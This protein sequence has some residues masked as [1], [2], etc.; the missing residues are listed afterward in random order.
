[1]SLL[2]THEKPRC[3]G[4]KAIKFLRRCRRKIQQDGITCCF[5]VFFLSL[6]SA[7]P[8]DLVEGETVKDWEYLVRL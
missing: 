1:M 5:K 7:G 4:G 6:V 3:E 8:G 2:V